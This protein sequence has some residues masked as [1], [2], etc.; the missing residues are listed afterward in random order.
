MDS[1]SFEKLRTSRTNTRD[2][3]ILFNQTE[4]FD[5]GSV[6]VMFCEKCDGIVF[7]DAYDHG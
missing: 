5:G 2:T 3:R 4:V 6:S 7:F 1:P